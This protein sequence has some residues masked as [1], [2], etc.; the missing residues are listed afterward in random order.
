[1]YKF[2]TLIV[3]SIFYVSVYS[4]YVFSAIYWEYRNIF[5]TMFK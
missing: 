4:M 1:M 2:K 3:N 5:E